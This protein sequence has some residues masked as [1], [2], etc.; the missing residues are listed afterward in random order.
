MMWG[1]GAQTASNV[2]VLGA[3]SVFCL[4]SLHK[5][6]TNALFASGDAIMCSYTGQGPYLDLQRDCGVGG[7]SDATPRHAKVGLCS[8][9]PPNIIKCMYI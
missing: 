6:L 9:A 5:E 4:R 3:Q 2:H 8:A 7:Q 1:V